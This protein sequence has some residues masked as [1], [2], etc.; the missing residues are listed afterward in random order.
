[1]LRH[2]SGSSFALL[3]GASHNGVTVDSRA[4][5]AVAEWLQEL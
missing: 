3:D 4:M 1:V 2:A 5:A